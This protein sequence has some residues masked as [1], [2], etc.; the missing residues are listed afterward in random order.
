MCQT[1]ATSKGV[2]YGTAMLHV[3]RRKQAAA[4]GLGHAGA[5][6]PLERTPAPRHLPT[7]QWRHVGCR[8]ARRS[9]RLTCVRPS[10]GSVRRDFWVKNYSAIKGANASLP[11]LLRECAGTPARLTAAFRECYRRPCP[12]HTLP[13]TDA[14][15]L[16]TFR[17]W[18][19]ADRERRGPFGGRIWHQAPVAH[20]G[21]VMSGRR[22]LCTSCSR[23]AEIL[24]SLG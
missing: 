17:G 10:T 7:P 4:A 19:G 20:E 11:I 21:A 2:R 18:Q 3:S 22:S 13:Q 15:C 5:T 23:R 1:S 8:P 16:P 24:L 12:S 6:Y 14:V 9:R